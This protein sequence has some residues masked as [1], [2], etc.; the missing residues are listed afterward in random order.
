MP[1]D[2]TPKQLVVE[3]LKQATNILVTVSHDPSI[4][5]LAAL[6]GL[7]LFLNKLE[8]NATAVFSGEIPPAI[9]FLEPDK[10]I[11][12]NVDSL[13]DFI[14][15]LDKSKADRLR[16]KVEGDLVRV[17]ITPYKT[18]ITEKDLNFSQGDFNVDLVVALGVEKK[19]D[20]DAAVTAHGRILHDA[21]TV[22]LNIT[23]GETSLGEIDW[24]DAESSSLC[25]MLVSLTEALQAGLLDQQIATAFLTG[26]VSATERFRN[27]K[28][29]PKVMTMAAQLMAAGANQQLIADK[30]DG[31]VVSERMN[32]V[33]APDDAAN[34]GSEVVTEN[35]TEMK[36]DHDEEDVAA[37]E[38][39][40]E[41]DAATIATPTKLPADE[42]V[43]HESVQPET[44]EDE[45]QLVVVAPAEEVEPEVAEPATVEPTLPSVQPQLSASKASSWRD[46]SL[47]P[48]SLGSALSATVAEAEEEKRKAEAEDHSRVLLSHNAHRPV[49]TAVTPP[50]PTTPANAPLPTAPL[51]SAT[52]SSQEESSNPLSIKTSSGLKF[53]ET[54]GG[55]VA[56]VEPQSP[57][58]PTLADLE[59]HVAQAQM[60]N[61]VSPAAAVDSAREAVDAAFGGA[62][63]NPATAEP[64]QSLGAQPL[65][66]IVHSDTAA[67]SPPTP[68]GAGSPILSTLPP[69]P[70][71][72]TLP[73][74]PGES[75][76]NASSP[77]AP[78]FG[79]PAEQAPVDSPTT[80]VPSNDAS[81]FRIPGQS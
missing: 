33:T 55:G 72:S 43:S 21:A 67:Q 28:T 62:P 18:T 59:A 14:I 3:R 23:G 75:P 50:V 20:I 6:L 52:Q 5:E 68:T 58:N 53:E 34:D 38:R 15:A 51:P 46:T 76:A 10:T 25:E 66:D 49:G 77:S 16:Y 41:V 48:P 64:L 69:L 31:A 2:Q 1:S 12:A 35:K 4:D 26:L 60:V 22:T 56:P 39:L 80:A 24:T 65:G 45:K 79:L 7:V 42:A 78:L 54:I 32:G 29:S 73:P 74:L 40:R 71:F 63:F 13:R 17:F 37:V 19:E 61:P 30:L 57:V 8:K 47:A 44:K 70:D 81:Q 36:V 9:S 11:E 27:Q